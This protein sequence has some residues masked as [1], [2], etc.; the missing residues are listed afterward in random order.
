MHKGSLFCKFSPV[1]VTS[2]LFDNSYPKRCEV[3]S[4][5]AFNLHFSEDYWCWTLFYIS[6]SHL[7]DVSLWKNVY[8][9]PSKE[10]GWTPGVGDGQGG[11]ACCSPWGCK[12]WD[13]TEW[14][15]WTEFLPGKFYGQGSLAAYNPWGHKRV[16]HDWVNTHTFPSLNWVVVF[17][18][19]WVD[20]VPCVFW[21]LT[22]YQLC[23]LQIFSPIPGLSFLFFFFFSDVFFCC[24][25]SF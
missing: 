23:D 16:R 5:C 15:N 6:V 18:C 17:L 10:F 24:I 3:T 1:Y 9:G 21:I 13:T 14:L 25:E 8:L 11:L 22:P 7:Y 2:C 19:Y 20:W 4:H 12:E